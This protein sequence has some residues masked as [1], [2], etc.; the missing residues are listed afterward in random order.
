M[1]QFKRIL[2]A[3]RDPGRSTQRSL[4][5]AAQLAATPG[6]HL[7]LF[8]AISDPLYADPVL[9]APRP[10]V[11]QEQKIRARHLDHLERLATPLRKK[12]LKVTCTAVWDFPAAHAI[13]RHGI[14]SRADLIVAE[15]RP[16]HG[17]RWFLRYTDWELLRLSPRPVLLI[18]SP[19]TYTSPA[20][21]AALDPSHG[22]EKPARLDDE[23]LASAAALHR[24]LGGTLHALHAYVPGAVGLRPAQMAKEGF[25]ERL[26]A[27][28]RARATRA[29]G[30]EL[31]AAR[32]SSAQR[33]VVGLHPV[34][35]IPGTARETGA[36]ITVMGAIS[37]SGLR[38]VIIGNT[39]EQVLDSLRCD[40]LVV[41]PPH[42]ARRVAAEARGPNLRAMMVGPNYF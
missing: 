29:I 9:T 24:Q 2:V 14:R 36:A 28:A 25:A 6:G 4:A 19:G 26:E 13:V 17:G 34:N 42:F 31:K 41:K 32:L 27:R 40:V 8:H 37:R 39:A 21:L 16:S 20:I 33:H 15:S 23:I 38:R 22:A 30:A 12:G 5:K 35:A 3:I 11:D 7:E 10:L 18:K 1:S